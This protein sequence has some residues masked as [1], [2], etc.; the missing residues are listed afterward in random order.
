MGRQVITKDATPLLDYLLA[1]HTR[2]AT[3]PN[4]QSRYIA[5]VTLALFSRNCNAGDAS[6]AVMPMM[7]VIPVMPAPQPQPPYPQPYCPAYQSQP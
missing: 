3:I 4:P 5:G 1:C 6:D 2:I 7:L